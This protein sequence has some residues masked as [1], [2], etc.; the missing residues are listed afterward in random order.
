M[1]Y[2]WPV[3][4]LRACVQ[5]ANLFFSLST[6]IFFQ[7]F[8]GEVGAPVVACRRLEVKRVFFQRHWPLRALLVG[9]IG[10]S[11]LRMAL[12]SS[13]SLLFEATNHKLDGA[14]LIT[15]RRFFF[16]HVLLWKHIF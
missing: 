4:H 9:N 3:T 13:L 12:V 14:G 16:F 6:S 1:F 11:Q 2:V 10:T 7:L 15:Q 5:T 8:P